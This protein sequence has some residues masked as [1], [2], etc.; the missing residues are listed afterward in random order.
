MSATT[1]AYKPSRWQAEF[2]AMP[3]DEGLGGGS[4]GPGKSMALLN[5]ANDQVVVEQARAAAKEITR[6][7]GWALHIRKE[8]PMLEQTIWRSK[9]LFP[10]LDSSAKY[11]END[12]KWVFYSSGYQYQFGHLKDPDSYLKYRSNEYTW[13]GF[14]ELVEIQWKDVYDE[15]VTRVRTADPVLQKMLKVRG[16]T[17]PAPGWVR[18]YFIEPN[19]NGREILEDEVTLR[20]GTKRIRTR[21]FL[22]AKLWDNPDPNFIS[23]YEASLRHRPKHIRAALLEGDWFV[24]PGAFFSDVWDADRVVIK[25]FKI[26]SGWHK[27]RSGDWGYKEECVILWWAVTPDRELICYRERTYNGT[28]AKRRMDAGEVARAIKEV[29]QAHGEWNRLKNC[30]RLSGPMDNQLWEERGRKGPTMADDMAKE[31]V[32][33]QRATK[34]RVSM[35]QQLITRLGQKGYDGRPGIMFFED[36]QKCIQTIPSI[37]TDELEPEKPKDG[38]PDHWYAAVGYACAANPVPSGKEDRAN[39]N[40]DDDEGGNNGAPFGGLGEFGYGGW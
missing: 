31:G 32:Y 12:H 36:C 27:F 10:V 22:P 28:K 26:P 29:E 34:G 33:W 30:S 15:L 16:V 25:P 11:S 37:G 1:Y 8:L 6:S 5:D 17:N 23:N 3:V 9:Q 20:D 4:V 14:D 40:D 35:A 21:M 2:H 13:L 38:G 24:V 18:D 7:K 19:R 39:D